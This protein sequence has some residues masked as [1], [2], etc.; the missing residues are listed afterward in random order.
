V[1]WWRMAS[2]R[3]SLDEW[4][5]A[6][7]AAASIRGEC[8]RRQVGAVIVD[9][10]RRQTWVAY[11]GGVPGEPSCLDGA[12]PRGRHYEV[13]KYPANAGSATWC[14]NVRKPGHGTGCTCK[15]QA[16]KCACGNELP[17]PDGVAPESSYD[18]GPGACTGTHAELGALMAAGRANLDSQC[19]MYVS[20]KPCPACERIIKGCLKRVVWPGGELVF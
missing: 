11:N 19:V 13:P 8:T 18:T 4:G 14:E 6:L 1:T 3:P 16:K 10:E 20:D 5:L 17:C 2:R 15:L 9:F 12:C 7:A